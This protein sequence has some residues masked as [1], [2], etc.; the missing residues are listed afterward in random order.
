MGQCP[1]LEHPSAVYSPKSIPAP[2]SLR[3]HPFARMQ[4][5]YRRILPW[6]LR[7]LLRPLARRVLAAAEPAGRS[8]TRLHPSS[9]SA[10][11]RGELVVLTANLWHDWP[12][13]RRLTQRLEAFARLV[14]AQGV[15]VVLLQEVMRTPRLRAD[16]WL[17]DRLGMSYVYSRANGHETGV[18]FEE[19]LAVFSRFPVLDARLQ[20]LEPTPGPFVRRLALGARVEAPCGPFWAFSVHLALGRQRNAAQLSHLRTWVEQVIGGESALI[21]GDFNAHEAAP[22]IRRVQRFWVDLFRKLNPAGDGTTHVL[23]WPWGRALLRQ[24]LDYLFLRP[25]EGRWRLLEAR[26]LEAPGEA[27]SDHRAVLARLAPA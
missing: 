9:V 13:K 5:I 24:R 10:V 7:A 27:H 12:R 19:G 6:P 1:N 23:R 21:G 25:G 16:E 18:G 14:E 8:L 26:L 20:Q 2:G 4:A 3:A 22:Q 17:S 11:G 15:D